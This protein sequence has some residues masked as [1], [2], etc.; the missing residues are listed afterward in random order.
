MFLHSR[1]GVL[2]DMV[3]VG[4]LVAEPTLIDVND[5]R[6]ALILPGA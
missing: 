2:P 4:G 5:F 3:D 1:C 6:A